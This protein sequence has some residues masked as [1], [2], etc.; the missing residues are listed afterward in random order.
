M[1]EG[2]F[3]ELL[4]VSPDATADEIRFAYHKLSLVHH[5]DRG[6]NTATFQQLHY[7]YETLADPRRKVAY[8]AMLTE[9]SPPIADPGELHPDPRAVEPIKRLASIGSAVLAA[10]SKALR[11]LLGRTHQGRRTHLL[12][13]GWI[14]AVVLAALLLY[15]LIVESSGLILLLFVVLAVAYWLYWQLAEDDH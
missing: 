5:P 2:T 9:L 10:S 15:F 8:D 11:T 3:Y 1:V 6:G 14:T 12:A 13:A 4:G 7:A